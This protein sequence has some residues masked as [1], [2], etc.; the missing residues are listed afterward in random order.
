MYTTAICFVKV[1]VHPKTN[2]YYKTISFS[3][4]VEPIFLPARET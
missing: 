4:I 1:S 3:T 2:H